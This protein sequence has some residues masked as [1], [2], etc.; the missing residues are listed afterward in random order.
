MNF[1]KH[2]LFVIFFSLFYCYIGYILFSE[3]F[4]AD[5]VTITYGVNPF[6]ICVQNPDLWLYIKITFF[7]TY[8]FSSF[9]ISNFLYHILLDF[10]KFF[11]NIFGKLLQKF[12]KI[13]ILKF[14]EKIVNYF[15]FVLYKIKNLYKIKK[16]NNKNKFFKNN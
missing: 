6:D 16:E 8:I 10:I 3:I 5:S 13:S 14:C 11:K 9:I 12:K 7:I 1:I 4:I 2:F 15:S